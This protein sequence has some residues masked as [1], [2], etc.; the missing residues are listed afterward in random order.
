[1]HKSPHADLRLQYCRVLEASL[2]ASLAVLTL[3]F[4]I[5]KKFEGSSVARA[6]DIPSIQVE[7]IPITRTIKRIEAPRKPTI[8]IEDPETDPETDIDLPEF[9]EF[10]PTIKPPP[11]PPA[12]DEIIP[13][14]KIERQPVLIGG[15]EAIRDYIVRNNLFPK[16]AEDARISGDVLIELVVDKEGLPKSIVVKQEKP[17]NLGFGEAAVKVMQAMRF[18]PGYQRDKPVQVRM[19]QRIRFAIE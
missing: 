2:A 7:D 12:L 1:M 16:V 13:F 6:V 9:S 8:P 11:P 15:P 17:P 3:S 5:W 10:D 18:Q 14:F 4:L 19:Q